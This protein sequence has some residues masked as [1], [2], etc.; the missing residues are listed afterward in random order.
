M[1]DYSKCA[2]YFKT[3]MRIKKTYNDSLIPTFYFQKH[4]KVK[5]IKLK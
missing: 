1:F 3:I 2:C 5:N 4:N